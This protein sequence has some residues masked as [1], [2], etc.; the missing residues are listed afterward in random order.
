[1]RN[2]TTVPPS[3][4]PQ[5]VRATFRCHGP[6]LSRFSIN[7]PRNSRNAMRLP[8]PF[9]SLLSSVFWCWLSMASSSPRR[10]LDDGVCIFFPFPWGSPFLGGD[11]AELSGL[12]VL[13][14]VFGC[15]AGIFSSFGCTTS[16]P[17]SFSL[18]P[19]PFRS[20]L[21]VF[22]APA[23]GWSFCFYAFPLIMVF[24]M[25]LPFFPCSPICCDC[26]LPG[27]VPLSPSVLFTTLLDT[28]IVSVYDANPPPPGR[29]LACRC[30]PVAY[31]S[32]HRRY[33]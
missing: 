16:L 26:H 1:M 20:P 19:I 23:G 13:M 24:I 32:F 29:V 11:F 31:R 9:F 8:P 6:P 30:P 21:L 2:R 22:G 7:N 25:P 18:C 5:N 3:S 33:P 27:F 17:P 4:T 14:Y 15:F 28:C 12:F 10:P